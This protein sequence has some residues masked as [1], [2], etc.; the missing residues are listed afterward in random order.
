[1][2]TTRQAQEDLK[3][4]LILERKLLVELRRFNKKMARKF[5]REFSRDSSIFQAEEMLPD[6][7]EMLRTHYANVS[8]R[9]KK[10]IRKQLTTGGKIT[11][12]E[13][14]II[15]DLLRD[16]IAEKV[17]EQ[18]QIINNTNQD[19][20]NKSVTLGRR[21]AQDADQRRPV[22]HMELSVIMGGILLRQLTSRAPR[23]A[24]TETQEMAER[25]KATEADVLSGQQQQEVQ[26][27]WVTVGDARVRDDHQRANG[28]KKILSL[29]Y[30]VGSDL[31]MYPGDASL[32]A[33]LSNVINCRCSSIHDSD[34][35]MAVRLNPD[36]QPFVSR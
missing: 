23:I 32:G 2:P 29:P 5:T 36:F 7:E 12:E 33:A 6:L 9:F 15:D 24:L 20:I 26:K 34:Q 25:S 16:A 27:T 10:T 31:L 22:S 21:V 35:I 3:Q 14:D 13:A 18:A 11:P 30:N 8:N 1:M 17:P 19:D 4:K 28:Q